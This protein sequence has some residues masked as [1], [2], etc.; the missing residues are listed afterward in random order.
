[1]Q[2][3]TVWG[4]RPI[5]LGSRMGKSCHCCSRPL[6]GLAPDC[7]GLP[8]AEGSHL[9]DPSSSDRQVASSATHTTGVS[10]TREVEDQRVSRRCVP[11]QKLH[12][13]Q[14]QAPTTCTS[15]TWQTSYASQDTPACRSDSTTLTGKI[16][17]LY[18]VGARRPELRLGL[19]VGQHGDVA[20]LEPEARGEQ[21][22]HA[23][24]VVDAP[25]QLVR[26]APVS[27]SRAARLPAAGSHRYPR[28]HCA[29]MRAVPHL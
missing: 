29:C 23:V 4:S 15:F 17:A 1:M 12:L 13:V 8:T 14:L 3:K 5:P 28:R 2:L 25:P 7:H 11:G 27:P 16:C 24:R 19:V 9:A 21:V 22:A 6:T 20:R 18:H 26:G 10:L